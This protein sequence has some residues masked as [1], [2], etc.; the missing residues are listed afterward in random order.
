MRFL[1]GDSQQVEVRS[2]VAVSQLCRDLEMDHPVS[3]LQ[4]IKLIHGTEQLPPSMRIVHSVTGS[5]D[6]APICSFE[7]F[8]SEVQAV[9]TASG[10][11]A[12]SVIEEFTR[13]RCTPSSRSLRPLDTE[14]LDEASESAGWFASQV[15]KKGSSGPPGWE[16]PWLIKEQLKHGHQEKLA[17][18][19]VLA[20]RKL[21]CLDGVS[22]IR[23]LQAFPPEWQPEARRLLRQFGKGSRMVSDPDAAEFQFRSRARRSY[24]AQS[25]ASRRS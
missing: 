20:L 18:E 19:A 24:P 25:L 1:N 3:P 13:V 17:R 10:E 14:D 6:L 12:V 9:L 8:P 22:G 23:L 11:K 4:E 5:G 16:D 15:A 7:E 21:D 2:G